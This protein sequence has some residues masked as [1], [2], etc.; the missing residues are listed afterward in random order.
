[1]RQRAAGDGGYAVGTGWAILCRETPP[2]VRSLSPVR[3]ADGRSSRPP[4]TGCRPSNASDAADFQISAASPCVP[5]NGT[6]RRSCLSRTIRTPRSR[7]MKTHVRTVLRIA[8]A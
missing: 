2:H 5:S 7:R 1:M 3:S 4:I 8:R 6:D